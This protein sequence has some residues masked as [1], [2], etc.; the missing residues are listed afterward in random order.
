MSELSKR[1]KELYKLQLIDNEIME[2]IRWVRNIEKVEDPVQKRY[3]ELT[4]KLEALSGDQTPFQDKAKELQDQNALLRDKKKQIEDKLFNPVTE[5]KELQF[6]QKEREQ[7]VNL[8]KAN[9]NE[10][11][12]LMTNVDGVE[13]KKNDIREQ[14][15][16]IEKDHGRITKERLENKEKYTKRI[17]ELKKERKKFKDFEDKELLGL[18]QRL[19][20]AHDGIAIA[21]VEEGI[22]T[23][24]N[25]EV[26]RSNEQQLVHDD[27]IVYCQ[28]CGRIL[29]NADTK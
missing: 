12:K 8:I 29:F 23:G 14:L 10:E 5:P 25:I 6:L 28:R 27:E 20:R 17:E 3:R 18:Y 15:K 11:V 16:E 4:A 1:I 21:T 22:C 26:S 19:Q 13:I 24:C 2:N 9:E 7:T